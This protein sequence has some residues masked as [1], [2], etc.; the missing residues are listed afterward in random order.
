M[1]GK[2]CIRGLRTTASTVLDLLAA[3]YTTERILQAY[4]LLEAE[5]IQQVVAHAAFRLGEQEI[6]LH[7]S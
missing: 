4:P 6:D 3:G 7:A 5:D 2:P 1:G